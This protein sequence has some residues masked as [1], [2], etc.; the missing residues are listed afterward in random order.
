MG[1]SIDLMTTQVQVTI[2]G[3]VSEVDH[4]NARVKRYERSRN[5]DEMNS[6]LGNLVG[7]SFV[8]ALD[9]APVGLLQWATPGNLHS[10][11]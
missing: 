9:K 2:A 10:L 6:V 1:L 11:S 3:L 7:G 4:L 8:H 5:T